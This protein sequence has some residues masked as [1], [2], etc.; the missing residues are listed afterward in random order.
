M[1]FLALASDYDGTLA[2]RGTVDLPTL[3]ALERL[4]ASGRRFLLVTGR[5]LEELLDI[6]PHVHFCSRIVVENGAVIYHPESKQIEIIATPP[7]PTFI[8]ELRRRGVPLSAGRVIVATSVGHESTVLDVIREQ[9]LE[10]Q[11]IFNKDAVMVLPAGV[12][13]ATGLAHVLRQLELTEHEVVGVGDA[14]NDHA[15]LALCE[16]AVAVANALPAIQEHA[17]LVTRGE[18][19]AGVAELIDQVVA[20]DLAD[21]ES[22]HRHDLLLGHDPEG[23]E[24]HVP[25]F[26]HNVLI[27][28]P[29][30][31]GKST[32]ATSFLERLAAVRYRYCI[33]DPEGDYSELEGASVIG[34]ARR[35]AGA[36]EVLHLLTTTETNTVV[37]MVG[38]PL[39]SRPPFFLSLLPGLL[40]LRARTGRPHWLVVDEAHHLLPASWEPGPGALPQTLRCVLFITVHPDLLA[41]VILR[42]VDTLIAVG[43]RPGETIDQFC[44]SV[45]DAQPNLDIA[46]LDTGEVLLWRRAEPDRPTR[47]R[48]IPSTSERRRH[49]RKYAEGEL[50]P[51]RSFYFTGAEGKLHLRAQ[52]LILFLQLADGVDDGTWKYH[53]RKG[54]Y[55]RWFREAIKDPEL[56]DEVALWEEE[57]GLPAK[58]SRQQVREAVERRYT[59]PGGPPL[60]MRG[61]DARPRR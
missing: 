54:D 41:P 50:P 36:D 60:P 29:S 12:N 11:V 18:Q 24:V 7:P 56:A 32:A 59:L 15:F 53:L 26:G 22:L 43:S 34:N 6:F 47:V 61:T 14:E 21:L 40:E 38:L 51:E 5:E 4:L 55:S 16:C 44:Q 42:S 28:G 30:G 2:H 8:Q 20:D 48:I 35:G 1:R 45:G 3:A 37:N 10:L 31:S 23:N 49:V 9:G 27:C 19:G 57:R 17:D 52:N 58:D 39:N 13:K 33:I 46:D 25:P